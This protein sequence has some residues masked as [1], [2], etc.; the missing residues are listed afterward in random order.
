ML[1]TNWRPVL[2]REG[3]SCSCA[4]GATAPAGLADLAGAA[5]AD[6]TAFRLQWGFR[7]PPGL[8][9]P[10]CPS[11]PSDLP[12]RLPGNLVVDMP[13][14]LSLPEASDAAFHELAR[15][16]SHCLPKGGSDD[17]TQVGSGSSSFDD[18]KCEVM[19]PW[20][21]KLARD[22]AMGTE[23]EA[24]CAEVGGNIQR[25]YQSQ[26]K[27]KQRQVKKRLRRGE[28]LTDAVEPPLGFCALSD[29]EGVPL[30]HEAGGVL[31]QVHDGEQVLAEGTCFSPAPGYLPVDSLR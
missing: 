26:R 25:R 30:R 23:A 4:E 7:P 5:R 12:K 31:A 19:P 15:P 11:L 27:K 2:R 29:S 8:A 17:E 10:C 6:V 14:G 18:L 16:P 21:S 24:M 3:G 9:E 28:T 20:P 13:P 1:A 22:N